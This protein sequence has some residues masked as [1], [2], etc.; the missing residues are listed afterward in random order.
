M[1]R[2][3]PWV[4]YQAGGLT[5]VGGRQVDVF[6][7][8]VDDGCSIVAE[9]EGL[10]VVLCAGSADKIHDDHRSEPVRS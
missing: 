8:R 3:I 2:R 6:E 10:L 5:A 4:C 1:T 7:D 9:G